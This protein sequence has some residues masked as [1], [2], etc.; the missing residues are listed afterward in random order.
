MF[1]FA[2]HRTAAGRARRSAAAGGAA[3]LI[4]LTTGCDVLIGTSNVETS[5][6]ITVTSPMLRE[7]ETIP[8]R[9]TCAGDGV[10]PPLRWSGLPSDTESLAL[11]VDE[12]ESSGGATVLWVVYG[13]DP[14]NPEFPEGSV[15][16]P[17]QQGQNSLGN[18]AYEPPCPEEGVEH[19]FRF[20]VYALS[21]QLDLGDSATLDVALGAIASH[22][23]ARG[24][25]TTVS[26]S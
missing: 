19:E 23:L 4:A 2:R 5:D 26:A 21:E 10:S 12:A 9:Y 15:P 14:V 3:A 7:G 20:T 13:I 24:R 25:L 18:A 17:A 8:A 22:T 6:D 16:Q 11:V 1:A